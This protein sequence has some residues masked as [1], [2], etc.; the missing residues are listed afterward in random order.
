MSKETINICP[1]NPDVIQV[2]WE[3]IEGPDAPKIQKVCITKHLRIQLSFVSEV[4][5]YTI[6]IIFYFMFD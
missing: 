6:A 3:F 5:L 1:N 2:P 4:N